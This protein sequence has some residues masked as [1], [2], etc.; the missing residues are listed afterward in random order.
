MARGQ[1]SICILITAHSAQAWTDREGK[2][3]PP[4][5]ILGVLRGKYL[6]GFI[7]DILRRRTSLLGVAHASR[8]ILSSLKEIVYY[9]LERLQPTP[10]AA[11]FG[12]LSPILNKQKTLLCM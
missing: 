6:T 10:L 11:I 5:G 1:A 8:L 12:Y 7:T 9:V 4:V 3:L 2:L